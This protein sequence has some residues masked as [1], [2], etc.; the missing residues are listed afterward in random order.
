MDQPVGLV[1]LQSELE[2]V[3][4]ESA[5]GAQA[6]VHK[7]GDY[8]EAYGLGGHEVLGQVLGPPRG[9]EALS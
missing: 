7:S 4:Q 1:E 2:Q 9:S 6:D 5:M 8:D 3:H